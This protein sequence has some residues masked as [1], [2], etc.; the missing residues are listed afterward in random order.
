MSSCGQPKWCYLSE[1]GRKS[2]SPQRTKLNSDSN[3][4]ERKLS[5]FHLQAV[6]AARNSVPH[7]F[8]RHLPSG[9]SISAASCEVLDR[10]MGA[11]AGCCEQSDKSVVILNSAENFLTNRVPAGFSKTI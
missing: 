9:P 4:G 3:E 7:T 10:L 5:V 8:R 6:L 11:V 2:T 1:S